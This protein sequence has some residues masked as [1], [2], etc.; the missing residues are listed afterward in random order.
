VG[1]GSNQAEASLLETSGE[2]IDIIDSELDLNFAIGSHAASIK[3]GAGSSRLFPRPEKVLMAQKGNFSP[4][5]QKKK[6]IY[7]YP[8]NSAAYAGNRA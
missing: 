3:K 1:A 6:F 8:L 7:R 2:G 4:S 5:L